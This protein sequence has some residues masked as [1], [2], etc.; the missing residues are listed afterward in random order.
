MVAANK[1]ARLPGLGLGAEGRPS[2]KAAGASR[3]DFGGIDRCFFAVPEQIGL[4]E[5]RPQFREGRSLFSPVACVGLLVP[6]GGAWFYLTRSRCVTTKPRQE[7]KIL[8]VT[9]S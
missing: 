8:T 1:R 7:P 6:P 3:A 2:R 5:P 9:D 4:P